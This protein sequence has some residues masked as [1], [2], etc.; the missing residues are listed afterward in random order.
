M[1]VHYTELAES[2]LVDIGLY[3]VEEWGVEQ[4]DRYRALLID[5]CERTIPRRLKRLRPV[6][7][8]P[9]LLRLRIESHVIY[10]RKVDDGIEIVRILHE[11]MLPTKH[12]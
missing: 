5:A 8:R 4:W 1:K 6:P 11:R 2:D 3:T 10:L 12:L 9:E 7:E